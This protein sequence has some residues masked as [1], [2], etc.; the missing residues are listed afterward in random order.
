MCMVTFLLVIFGNIFGGLYQLVWSENFLESS[1]SIFCG[2][3]IWISLVKKNRNYILLYLVLNIP[4]LFVIIINRGLS[5]FAEITFWLSVITQYYML[6]IYKQFWSF[7]S[8]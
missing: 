7:V 3:L 5:V 8:L 1:G 6:L 2:A 4:S